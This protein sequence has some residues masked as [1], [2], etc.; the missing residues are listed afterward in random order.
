[1]KLR[2][3]SGYRNARESYLAGQVFET[4]ADH[5]EFLQRDAP[6]VFVE[7]TEAQEEVKATEQPPKDKAVRAPAKNKSS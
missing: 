3:L 5:A 4:T 6:G 1:M 7:Y 2:A